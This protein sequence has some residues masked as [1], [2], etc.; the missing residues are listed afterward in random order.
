[1]GA[2][3]VRLYRRRH[4]HHR[5]VDDLTQPRR[6]LV[7]DP[8]LTEKFRIITN[9]SPTRAWDAITQNGQGV[10]HLYGLE[11]RSTWQPGATLTVG[12][13]GGEELTGQVLHAEPPWR[14]SYTL[15]P[16]LDHPSAYVTWDIQRRSDSTIVRLY[17]DEPDTMDGTDIE[18]AWTPVLASL[19]RQL[20]ACQP[21]GDRSNEPAPPSDRT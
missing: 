9:A 6:H 5:I 2:L 17:I 3:N 18:L 1:M 19:E 11:V 7:M 21:P 14:L 10:E 16:R 8:I 13:A 12:I 15:G 4:G 20:Q